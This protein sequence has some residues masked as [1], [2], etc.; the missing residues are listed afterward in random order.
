MPQAVES[1]RNSRRMSRKMSY[2]NWT[3]TPSDRRRYSAADGSTS[4]GLEENGEIQ[5]MKAQGRSSRYLTHSKSSKNIDLRRF[6]ADNYFEEFNS[7]RR[8]SKIRPSDISDISLAEE[9]I[10]ENGEYERSE[11]SK[12]SLSNMKNDSSEDN[13]NGSVI[14]S[15][16]TESHNESEMTLGDVSLKFSFFLIELFHF[17][18]IS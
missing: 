9:V 6:T 3:F 18:I 14:H 13:S 16:S 1:R 12:K 10:P 2:T 5:D 15:A 17:A 4:N 7:N 8:K 11:Y